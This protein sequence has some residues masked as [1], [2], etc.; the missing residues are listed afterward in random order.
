MAKEVQ[1]LREFR[2]MV[3]MET[4]AG[5][6]FMEVFHRFYYSF[7]PTVARLISSSDLA[8]SAIRVVI[9]PLISILEYSRSLSSHLAHQTEGAAVISGIMAATMIGFTY[10]LLPILILQTVAVQLNRRHLKHRR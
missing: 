1:S 10:F 6:Q 4:F 2:D 8:R 5:K 9:C 3:I 7:S